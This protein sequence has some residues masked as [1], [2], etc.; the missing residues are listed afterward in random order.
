MQSLESTMDILKPGGPSLGNVLPHNLVIDPYAEQPDGADAAWMCETIY[1]PTAGLMEKFTF[2]E[3]ETTEK[4]PVRNL[5]Y[6]PTH[7]AA[8]S[9][10]AMAGGA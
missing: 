8:F 9:D 3:D 2:K 4:N 6:K 10:G 7:K 1:F 5:I